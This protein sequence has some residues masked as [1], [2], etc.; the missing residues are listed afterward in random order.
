MFGVLIWLFRICA[1]IR[2]AVIFSVRR[3]VLVMWYLDN[4]IKCIFG[5]GH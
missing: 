4:F 5:A 2:V 3:V 1:I